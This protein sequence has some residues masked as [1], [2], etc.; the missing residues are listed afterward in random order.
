MNK[1]TLGYLKC[2][3]DVAFFP[4]EKEIGFGIMLW[5]DRSLFVAAKV[6][7]FP[8]AALVKEMEAACLL[9]A[10][11]WVQSLDQSMVEFEVDAKVVVEDLKNSY[12][13]L[14]EFGS[15]LVQCQLVLASET[16]F[17]VSFVRRQE[18]IIAHGL[19]GVACFYASPTFF[20]VPLNL[21]SSNNI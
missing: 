5:D 20:N 9:N 19:A 12:T 10:L 4:N 8:G 15:I 14:T 7:H 18:N 11:L 6:V 3:I 1:P 21:F 2:N 13:D 16:N 17:S